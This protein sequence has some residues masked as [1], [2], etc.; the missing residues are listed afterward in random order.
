MYNKHLHRAANVSQSHMHLSHA[1]TNFGVG[2]K[3]T[4]NTWLALVLSWDLFTLNLQT[5]Q[6]TNGEIPD[7][8]KCRGQWQCR[9]NSGTASAGLINPK[10]VL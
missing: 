9:E 7:D 4:L 1:A 8:V 3:I 6:F 2:A 5:Y 10:L